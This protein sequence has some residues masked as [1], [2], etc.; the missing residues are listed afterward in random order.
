MP[1]GN[2]I[3]CSESGAGVMASSGA[4]RTASLNACSC[5]S[6]LM[7]SFSDNYLST[8]DL[9]DRHQQCSLHMI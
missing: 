8:A 5:Y 7:Q 2:V 3:G 1:Y 9:Y 6:Q 4:E